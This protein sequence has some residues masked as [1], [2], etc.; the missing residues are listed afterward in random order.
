MAALS[1]QIFQFPVAQLVRPDWSHQ[2]RAEIFRYVEILG[3]HGVLVEVSSGASDEGDPWFALED[4]NTGE[5]LIHIARIDGGFVVSLFSDQKLRDL[6]GADLRGLL[7]EVEARVLVANEAAP[8]MGDRESV[9][10]G[11]VQ[12]VH[13]IIGMVGLDYAFSALSAGAATIVTEAITTGKAEQGPVEVTDGTVA[14]I[15]AIRVLIEDVGAAIVAKTLE[16]GS[17]QADEPQSKTAEADQDQDTVGEKS[18]VPVAIT[19]A[20]FGSVGAAAQQD[21]PVAANRAPRSMLGTAPA[22]KQQDKKAQPDDLSLQ[23]LSGTV[24]SDVLDAGIGFQGVVVGGSGDDVIRFGAGATVTGQ[25]GRDVFVV[26]VVVG[27]ELATNVVAIANGTDF[28]PAFDVLVVE[29]IGESS[30]GS[31][32]DFKLEVESVGVPALDNGSVAPPYDTGVGSSL[33]L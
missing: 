19:D 16:S 18:I 24:G 33:L 5:V 10:R 12:L 13:V 30:T 3:R 25:E 11:V 27:D 15:E 29:A 9:T 7:N 4:I 6:T 1:A 8:D 17:G 2:E 22:V 23:K 32:G 28:D 20:T 26:M 31:I 14:W 21:T